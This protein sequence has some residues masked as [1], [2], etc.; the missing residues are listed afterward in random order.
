MENKVYVF[1]ARGIVECTQDWYNSILPENLTTSYE[2]LL[3]GKHMLASEDQIEFYKTHEDAD[4]YHL[5]YM[6]EY[7]DEEKAKIRE[8]KNTEISKTREIL[9]KRDSDPLYMSFVKYSAQ[10]LEEKA[11][12]AFSQWMTK[13][14]EIENNNPYIE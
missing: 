4:L 5:F 3:L 11:K 7:T 14:K 13:V 9:Y 2:E 1:D 10:G 8:D 6:L 12:E